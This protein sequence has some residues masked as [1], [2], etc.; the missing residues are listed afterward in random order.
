[1]SL[2][3]SAP[4]LK[5]EFVQWNMLLNFPLARNIGEA[6]AAFSEVNLHEKESSFDSSILIDELIEIENSLY[7]LQPP[8]W[9]QAIFGKINKSKAKIGK[10]LYKQ[11]CIECHSVKPHPR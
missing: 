3:R 4:N 8:K 11:H 2:K 10:S 6:A 9:G 5:F 1:M 7:K